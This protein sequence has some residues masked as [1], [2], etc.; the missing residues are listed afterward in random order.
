MGRADSAAQIEARDKAQRYGHTAM[1]FSQ[2]LIAWR[3]AVC[4]GRRWRSPQ[5]RQDLPW[6][7]G[8]PCRLQE[9]PAGDLIK[10]WK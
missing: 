8:E 6:E 2:D 4:G 7:V 9:V 3:L 5:A 10:A 1:D